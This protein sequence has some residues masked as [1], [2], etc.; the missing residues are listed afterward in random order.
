[1]DIS[2][3]VIFKIGINFN[4]IRIKGKLYVIIGVYK[5]KDWK[6]YD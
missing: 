3:I 2:Y 6:E 4:F 1:M 5:I